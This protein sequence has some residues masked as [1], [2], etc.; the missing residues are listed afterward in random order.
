MNFNLTQRKINKSFLFNLSLGS[1]EWIQL[2]FMYFIP[3]PNPTVWN[4][5]ITSERSI[6]LFAFVGGCVDQQYKNYSR[7][8]SRLDWF[9]EVWAIICHNECALLDLSCSVLQ[10]PQGRFT[11]YSH[12]SIHLISDQTNTV[13]LV[14]L[15][16]ADTVS[17]RINMNTLNKR[18]K[19]ADIF[20]KHSYAIYHHIQYLTEVSTVSTCKNIY[21]FV[22]ILLYLFMWQHWRND[23]LLQM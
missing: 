8:N 2:S 19:I 4:D 3:F 1:W 20:L 7:M 21:I 18:I 15:R 22:N 13:Q 14:L 6:D 16:R 10:D 11:L 12:A 9:L 23:T 17:L 5:S